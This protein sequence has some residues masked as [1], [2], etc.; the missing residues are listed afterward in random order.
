MDLEDKL[1]EA[2]HYA[3]SKGM[4]LF[5]GTWVGPEEK[6]AKFVWSERNGDIRKFLDVASSLGARVIFYDSVVLTEED[7][8]RILDQLDELEE[9]EEV[10]RL[11]EELR[12]F[13]VHVG[14]VSEIEVGFKN[15]DEIYFYREQADW[16]RKL[17]ELADR[18]E[19]LVED[20]DVE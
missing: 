12:S 5:N 6:Y 16:A 17:S 7:L 2:K 1:E 19:E 10:Q 3:L 11:R 9:D 8:T 15:S 20:Q 4:V 13:L 18:V 14:E